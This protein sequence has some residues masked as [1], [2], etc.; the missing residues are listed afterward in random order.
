MIPC[1]ISC[2]SSF[3]FGNGFKS[4]TRSLYTFGLIGC[5]IKYND[6]LTNLNLLIIN[7]Y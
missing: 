1:V 7:I 6:Y 4:S 2:V 5:C 3:C